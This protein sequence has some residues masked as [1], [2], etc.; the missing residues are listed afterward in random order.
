M[1]MYVN[2]GPWTPADLPLQES[3]L[4]T[5]KDIEAMALYI[6]DEE[7]KRILKEIRDMLINHPTRH[8]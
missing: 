5:E 3:R 1:A 2:L 4:Y 6:R 7:D 8:P